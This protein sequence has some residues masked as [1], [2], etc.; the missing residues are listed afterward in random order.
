MMRVRRAVI[1]ARSGFCDREVVY[2]YYRCL[3]EG[4]QVD[5]ATPDGA[6]VSGSHGVP[7]PLDPAAKP[8]VS[9]SALQAEEYDAALLPGGPVGPAQ[10]DPDEQVGAFLRAMSD[11]GKVV[12]GLSE[13]AW[14][15]AGSG[16]RAELEMDFARPPANGI[17]VIVE[18]NWVTCTGPA[19]VGRLM[20]VVFETTERLAGGGT[21]R[22]AA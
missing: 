5:V 3:E 10:D 6:P 15:S 12:A 20:R 21:R 17:D 13:E 7:V 1:I 14:M 22:P 18:G 11:G 16:T 2:A 9:F 4:W 19:H 8:N